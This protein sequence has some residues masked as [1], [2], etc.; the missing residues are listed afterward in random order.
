MDELRDTADKLMYARRTLIDL[1]ASY[2][3]MLVTVP[4][5]WVGS[6]FGFTQEKGLSMPDDDSHSKV[7]TEDLKDPKVSL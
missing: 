5:A 1:T 3:T 2:N 4:S 7:T 6:V